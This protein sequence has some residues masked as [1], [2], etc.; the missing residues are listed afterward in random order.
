MSCNF[1]HLSYTE[2][3]I[4]VSLF[5]KEIIRAIAFSVVSIGGIFFGIYYYSQTHISCKVEKVPQGKVMKF[6]KEKIIG[7]SKS[8]SEVYRISIK[9]F[10]GR[11]R[12]LVSDENI[13]PIETYPYYTARG[14]VTFFREYNHFVFPV[15]TP[16]IPES[17]TLLEHSI[18]PDVQEPFILGE[19]I[20]FEQMLTFS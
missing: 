9:P 12:E 11:Y 10:F 18:T 16:F 15:D 17:Y 6:F 7:R 19:N 4:F 8:I 3:H 2:H 20:S 14:S 13:Q 5:M 1:L